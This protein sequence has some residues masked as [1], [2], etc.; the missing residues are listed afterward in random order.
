MKKFRFLIVVAIVGVLSTVYAWSV[1]GFRVLGDSIGVDQ[2]QRVGDFPGSEDLEYS[3]NHN[4]LFISS[5][6]RKNL[7]SGAVYGLDPTDSSHSIQKL[8]GDLP[9]PFHPHGLTS[10]LTPDGTLKIYVVNHR[11]IED[12]IEV[13]RARANQVQIEWVETLRFER[14]QSLN[15]L[16]AVGDRE[17]YVTRDHR[18]RHPILHRAEDNLRLGLGEILKYDGSTWTVVFTGLQFPNGI[19]VQP[20]ERSNLLVAE[21]MKRQI[22]TLQAVKGETLLQRKA[23]T[24]VSGAPDNLSAS[25]PNAGSPAS[26]EVLISTHSLLWELGIHASF[27]TFRSAWQTFSWS[28]ESNS[29]ESLRLVHSD[30]ESKVAAGVSTVLRVGGTFYLGQIFRSGILICPR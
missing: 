13:F 15:D 12:T 8:T 18:Y 3:P 16:V 11:P 17:L 27:P 5:D 19:I 7:D 24:S 1:D 26:S 21:M 9:F 30:P 4:R 23:V 2:C 20:G 22:L 29:N 10:R 6:D 28:A 14:F 25:Y